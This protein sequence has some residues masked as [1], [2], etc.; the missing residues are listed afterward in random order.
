MVFSSPIFLFVFFPITLGCYYLIKSV[1]PGTNR[2]AN[3]WLLIA[4]IIFYLWGAPKSAYLLF[5]CAGIIFDFFIAI[6]IA[7]IYKTS[8]LTTS[9]KLLL[10]VAIGLNLVFLAY[11]KYANF[12]VEV[13]V[14][15]TGTAISNWQAVILPIG[16]S[17]I[18]FHK[19]SYLVD[20]YR[21][22]VQPRQ[23]LPEF[24]LYLL[25]FPQLIAGPIVRYHTITDQIDK[26]THSV[27][28]VFEGM[29]RFALGL[30]KKVLLAN[31]LG[32]VADSVFAQPV[33][34]LDPSLAWFGIL[35]YALQIYFDF[36]GYSDMAIGLGKMFGFR[37]PEN[38][39]RP[40]TAKSVSEFWRRWHISLSSFFRDYVYI[41]LGGNHS[42]LRRTLINLW[43]VFIL[44]GLWHG[45]KWTFL[46]WG[47]Y[48][49][50]WLTLERLFLARILEKMPWAIA[51]A[52]TF[53]VILVG[54]VFFRSPDLSYAFGYIST[55]FDLK[56]RAGAGGHLYDLNIDFG[57]STK[58]VISMI[59]GLAACFLPDS[60]VGRLAIRER[61]QTLV[62]S[63]ATMALLAY[64]LI[65]L[66]SG[67]FNPFL[68]FQF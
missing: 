42:T 18:V 47:A 51:N 32:S 25:F 62:K 9:A 24:L 6:L 60:L 68:Y 33:S 26:R 22:K 66:A 10:A 11:Y 44:C 59:V 40:Y 53:M 55:M 20:V 8:N 28:A 17:F 5:F 61:H 50:F 41:P 56:S 38:F 54:W 1:S 23:S 64:S 29:H 3:L 19:I 49:G 7:R 57:F 65:T 63:L 67:T 46:F 34:S 36:S 43:I 13:L 48:Y 16:I 21:R 45:A 14:S 58:V 15:G 27:N 30:G 52:Y 31:P 37:L 12:F 2:F 35:M 4:S 39:N